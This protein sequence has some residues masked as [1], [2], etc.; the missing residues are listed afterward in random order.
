MLQKQREASAAATEGAAISQAAGSLAPTS[1]LPPQP[2]ATPIVN[3]EVVQL[4]GPLLQGL[5]PMSTSQLPSSSST[6]PLPSAAL[7]SSVPLPEFQGVSEENDLKIAAMSID[8]IKREQEELERLLSPGLIK[9]LRARRSNNTGTGSSSAPNSTGAPLQHQQREYPIPPQLDEDLLGEQLS[10]DDRSSDEDEDDEGMDDEGQL[11]KRM[12]E[13]LASDRELEKVS[14]QLATQLES[15]KLEFFQPL[16]PT[17]PIVW[18]TTVQGYKNDSDAWNSFRVDLQGRFIGERR[19]NEKIEIIE[20]KHQDD[21]EDEKIESKSVTVTDADD[22]DDPNSALYHHGD[23]A[24]RP[25]YTMRELLHL[26]RSTVAQQRTWSLQLIRTILGR[27]R[28]GEYQYPVPIT[29]T[30]PQGQQSA[31]AL[32][33]DSSN[34][35]VPSVPPFSLL[36]FSHLLYLN[37]LTLI[38]LSLDDNRNTTGILAASHCLEELFFFNSRMVELDHVRRLY[39]GFILSKPFENRKSM[40]DELDPKAAQTKKQSEAKHNHA[41]TSVTRASD[42]KTSED[43]EEQDNALDEEVCAKDVIVGLV[44]MRVLDRIRYMLEVYVLPSVDYRHRLNDASAATLS[45]S[46]LRNKTTSDSLAGLIFLQPLFHLLLACCHHS[47]E[48]LSRVADTP[49]LREMIVKI[50]RLLARTV[51][52]GKEVDKGASL[53]VLG[54]ALHTGMHIVM[55]LSQLHRDL[56]HGFLTF[57]TEMKRFVVL[58]NG[59]PMPNGMGGELDSGIEIERDELRLILPIATDTL[60]LWR[61]CLA[62]GL[63]CESFLDHYPVLLGMISRMGA[64]VTNQSLASSDPSLY[65]MHAHQLT[66]ALQVLDA[67]ILL[68]KPQDPSTRAVLSKSSS[69]PPNLSFELSHLVGAVDEILKQIGSIMS[70]PLADGSTSSTLNAVFALLGSCGHLLGNYFELLPDQGIFDS[71]QHQVRLHRTYENIFKGIGTKPIFASAL[72]RVATLSIQPESRVPSFDNLPNPCQYEMDLQF[73][74]DLWFGLLHWQR[75]LLPRP[76]QQQNGKPSVSTGATTL[77]RMQ[78][79]IL[80]ATHAERVRLLEHFYRPVTLTATVNHAPQRPT[81]TNR[82]HQPAPL[83]T[84]LESEF[85]YLLIDLSRMDK[86]ASTDPTRRF[87]ALYACALQLIPSLVRNGQQYLARVVLNDILFRPDVL[88]RLGKGHRMPVESCQLLRTIYTHFLCTVKEEGIISEALHQYHILT[89]TLCRP[90][91][92]LNNLIANLDASDQRYCVDSSI[93]GSTMTGLVSGAWLLAPLNHNRFLKVELEKSLHQRTSKLSV[94][95][96]VLRYL[97]TIDAVLTCFTPSVPVARSASTNGSMQAHSASTLFL[98]SLMEL[99]LLGSDIF[100]D[101]DFHALLEPVCAKLFSHAPV[102]TRSTELIGSAVQVRAINN[103]GVSIAEPSGQA[104][105]RSQGNQTVELAKPMPT[106]DQAV[107]SSTNSTLRPFYDL[108]SSAS[109]PTS[110]W[111]SSFYPFFQEF[112]ALFIADSMGDDLFASMITLFLRQEYSADYRIALWRDA[113]EV[114]TSLSTRLPLDKLSYLFPYETNSEVLSLMT[115]SLCSV[116]VPLTRHTNP[117]LYELAIHHLAI[118]LFGWKHVDGTTSE[119]MPASERVKRVQEVMPMTLSPETIKE[120][121]SYRFRLAD[122]MKAAA[123]GEEKNDN[124]PDDTDSSPSPIVDAPVPTPSPV[125]V[126]SVAPS[127][128]PAVAASTKVLT[129][130]DIR[131]MTPA[132]LTPERHAEIAAKRAEARSKPPLAVVAGGVYG[133]ICP[134]CTKPNSQTTKLCTGC[135]FELAPED[136]ARLPTNIFKDIVDN[137]PTAAGNKVNFRGVCEDGK[138]YLVLEDK[139]GTSLNHLDCIPADV[140][141]DITVLTRDHIPM[142][143][144]LYKLGRDELVSRRVPWIPNDRPIDEFI[145]AGFN[146]PVSVHHLH[147]HMVLG[148][149]YHRSIF[150]YPRWHSYAKVINDL[151]EYGKVRLYHDHPC[152]EEGKEVYDRAIRILEEL[153]P[154][155]DECDRM[156]AGAVSTSTPQ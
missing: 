3:R 123:S 111:G 32:V 7:R 140:Y 143:E 54:Q 145:T 52:S 92:S 98:R 91:P 20:E 110:I 15:A 16:K 148:P 40:V 46:D 73:A 128:A 88:A 100:L 90:T 5:M 153:Q 152:P 113:V 120:L 155:K 126:G 57:A 44:R 56:A 116:T 21:G 137:L 48:V 24:D 136:L 51:A 141:K 93:L 104:T 134:C 63:D 75:A 101:A 43:Q 106:G 147:L 45:S 19:L 29:Q 25:G 85:V 61:I 76:P 60:Q 38:R 35:A 151:K 37:M 114:L 58:A 6:A 133:L 18:P 139:F 31:T 74:L 154:L 107:S 8:E 122:A 69:P 112:V 95:C 12:K 117:A 80:S 79:D 28:R 87:V 65:V 55:A 142:L 94:V 105:M 13:R 53:Q 22:Y 96:D 11:V 64:I 83:L 62:Y 26:M 47:P 127:F 121:H 70:M 1:T 67:L 97:L 9:M 125:T 144:T 118:H 86:S 71:E 41:P 124:N 130:E 138:E 36:L 39:R 156:A 115:R 146:C 149:Y 84:P 4:N 99:Y 33:E 68:F 77:D 78:S 72:Q 82:F 109:I 10:A 135:A 89:P 59:I 30:T 132:N 119:E 27:I 103:F 42:E 50:L 108:H 150:T 2:A 34:L 49:R 23:Q 129:I 81:T 14:S 17:G 66:A 131:S 102:Q